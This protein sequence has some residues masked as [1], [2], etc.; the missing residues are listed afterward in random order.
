MSQVHSPYKKWWH[1]PVYSVTG[2]KLWDQDNV[3]NF[4]MFWLNVPLKSSILHNLD[5]CDLLP[6]RS[7][8]Q[9]NKSLYMVM[10]QILLI[11]DL[12]RFRVNCSKIQDLVLYIQI[13]ILTQLFT[14]MYPDSFT[15]LYKFYFNSLDPLFCRFN[16]IL[17]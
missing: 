12:L 4:L 16:N 11:Y 10:H 9:Y 7:T 15:I 3:P 5:S 17:K 6:T 14:T 1:P 13:S 2:T 8:N